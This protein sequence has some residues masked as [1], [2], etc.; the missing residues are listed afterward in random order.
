M[1]LR[2]P[3]YLIREFD[4]AAGATTARR[5]PLQTG[6]LQ[7]A[8]AGQITNG[9]AVQITLALTDLTSV[10]FFTANLAVGSVRRGTN[11]TIVDEVEID[12]DKRPMDLRIIVVN[13]TGAIVP[14]RANAVI[15]P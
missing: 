4:A 9:P 2:R 8:N 13:D 14:I 1:A 11:V 6:T 3:L 7:L 10:P 15:R 12:R 5:I